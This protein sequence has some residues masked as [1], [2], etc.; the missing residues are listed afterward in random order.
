MNDRSIMLLLLYVLF[1]PLSFCFLTKSSKVSFR[2]SVF[3]GGD[4]NNSIDRAP[5]DKVIDE[6]RRNLLFTSF[7]SVCAASAVTYRVPTAIADTNQAG[8]VS[9]EKI[10][11]ML[12]AIPTFTIV[13]R[14][15]VPYMVVGEDAK[16]TGY[17]FT[18]H[19]EAARILNVARTTADKA[20]REA[21]DDPRQKDLVNKMK[22]PWIEAR[23]STVPMD[24]AVTV[25]TKSISNKGGVFQ[26][27]PADEDVRDALAIIGKEDLAEGKIPIFYY[28]DF[29]INDTSPLFFNK[30]QLEQ[31]YRKAYPGATELPQS[32]VTELFAVL[33]EMVR[34]GG[35]DS[36]LKSIAFVPPSNSSQKARECERKGGKESPFIVGER[37]I[38]L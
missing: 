22:N 9:R 4:E 29:T 5:K 36:D 10:A 28:K 27:A 24:V 23:I 3:G 16:V 33:T 2:L 8:L 11:D 15:G 26:I 32:Q 13:D 1:L 25:V 17:F 31:A 12:R 38:V 19:D 30:S 35:A 37:N 7:N 6:Q 20:I 18:T 21:R 34:P 14:R